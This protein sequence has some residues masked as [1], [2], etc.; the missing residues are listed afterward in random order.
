LPGGESDPTSD[1]NY[2]IMAA[3]EFQITSSSS[4]C[5]EMLCRGRLMDREGQR[6]AGFR[7]VTR[8]W[9]G[10]RVI[11]FEIEIDPAHLPEDRPWNSYYACRFAWHDEVCSLF[12]SVNLANQPTEMAQLE[13][14]LF[15]DICSGKLR[16]TIL[17]GGL[18]YHRRIGPR[19]LDTLLIVPGETARKFRIGVG[20]DVPNPTTA[21]LA[22]ID[23]PLKIFGPLKPPADSGWLFHLDHRNVVA[24]AWLLIPPLPL[25]EGRDEGVNQ[26]PKG[27]RVRLLE[28]E[29]RPAQLKLRC[30]YPVAAARKLETGDTPPAELNVEGD[31]VHIPM[32]PHQWFDVEVLFQS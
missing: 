2:S 29:G 30:L 14:P 18:P 22:F 3:D 1:R 11:E 19:K 32:G 24:T 15:I 26:S 12:R 23:P 7:Q 8:V 16:T 28:T 17:G 10:S 20:L 6:L 13:S 9:R 31:A 5:G 27:F 21:A 4:V 25:G